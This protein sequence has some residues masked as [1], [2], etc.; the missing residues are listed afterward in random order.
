MPSSLMTFFYST[1]LQCCQDVINE[2]F[3]SDLKCDV[4]LRLASLHMQE[5]AI[6]KQI[7]FHKITIKLVE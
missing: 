1:S 3:S 4:A 6:E 2:R 7:P 5:Q